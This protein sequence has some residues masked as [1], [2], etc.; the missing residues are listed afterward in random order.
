MEQMR[1]V[2]LAEVST[3]ETTMRNRYDRFITVHK[4]FFHVH[5]LQQQRKEFVQNL[6]NIHATIAHVQE[7]KM[8]YKGALLHLPNILK[9]QAELEK[10]RSGF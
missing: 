2:I 1:K 7:C 10:G 9:P 3:L 6:R 4:E 8:W 5:G